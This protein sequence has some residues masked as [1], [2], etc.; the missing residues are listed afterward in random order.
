MLP[1][2]I[3]AVNAETFDEVKA[4]IKKVE[5]YAEG[6][7]SAEGPDNGG[8]KWVHVDVADGSFTDV[9]LWHDPNDLLNLQ[10]PLCVEVH[11]MIDRIDERVADW[12]KPVVR[13]VIFHREASENPNVVIDACRA[14]DIQAGIAI[15]PD[16][17]VDIVLPFLSKVD[18]VQT[19]AVVPGPS[20]QAFR[21]D[22]L[23]KIA[24]LHSAYPACP[25]EVDGGVNSSTV[26]AI[27]K[28]GATILV[29]G[30]AIYGAADIKNAIEDLR[31]H[32]AE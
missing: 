14:A 15:K 17:S 18:L 25:I 2:L 7:V 3:P 11:L 13:R 8:I 16:S 23:Q 32:A 9:M 5:P 30:A 28:A 29:A 24:A 21:S 4:K 6:A 19:L 22:T 31:R 26:G 1:E 27:V 12:L 20:G 10:T